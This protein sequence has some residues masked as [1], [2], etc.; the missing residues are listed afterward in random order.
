[1]IPPHAIV[2]MQSVNRLKSL[3]D[4]TDVEYSEQT[5]NTSAGINGL[6]NPF[7]GLISSV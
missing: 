3:L 1:M 7:V 2:Y 5:F 6:K 4:E